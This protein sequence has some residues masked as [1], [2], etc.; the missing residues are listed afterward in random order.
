MSARNMAKRTAAGTLALAVCLGGGAIA[1]AGAASADANFKFDTRIAGDDRYATAIAA[2]KAAFDKADNVILVNGYATVDGLTASYLAGVANAP[3]LYVSDKGADDATKA[4]IKRLGAKNIWL[5]G[6]EKVIPTSVETAIKGDGYSVT[7]INGSDRYETAALIAE[8]GIK[9]SG[10]KPSKVFVASGTSFADALAVSPVAFVKGYP[11][12]LTEKDST[13]DFSKKELG[14][15]GTDSK[16]LVGGTAVVS[17]KVA[18]DLS[19]KSDARVAGADRAVTANLISDWAKKSEGFN[20]ANAALVGGTNGNGADSLVASALLGKSYTTLHFAGWDATSVYFKDHAAELTGKGFVFGGKAAV[21]EGQVSAAQSAAQFVAPVGALAITSDD[22]VVSTQGSR[23]YSVSGLKA[24]TEYFVA[25]VDPAQVDNSMFDLDTT[26]ATG[27]RYASLTLTPAVTDVAIDQKNGV[28]ITEA[29]TTT[30]TPSGST[31]SFRVKSRTA[32]GT[33]VVPVI[34][35]N[36]GVSGKLAVNLAGKATTQLAGVGGQVTFKAPVAAPPAEAATGN[37][38]TGAV[39]ALYGSTGF[40]VAGNTGQFVMRD[41]DTY[42]LGATTI[43]KA[44]F[45]SILGVGDTIAATR[46]VNGST[47]DDRS[48]FT[49]NTNVVGTAADPAVDSVGGKVT[50]TYTPQAQVTPNG[51]VIEL[52]R[53]SVVGGVTGSYTKLT[54]GTVAS[55]DEVKFTETLA[56]GTYKYQLKYITPG[57]AGTATAESTEVSH[58]VVVTTPATAPELKRLYTTSNASDV[59]NLSKGDTIKV[60]VSAPLTQPVNGASLVFGTSP[61]IVTLTAAASDATA[62][63]S[64]SFSVNTSTEVVDGVSQAA[65][66]VLTVKLLAAPLLGGTG[67]AAFGG[68]TL[69]LTDSTGIA[70]PSGSLVDPTSSNALLR[71]TTN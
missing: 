65:G 52:Y 34:F 43:T 27:N 56:D 50:V 58:N 53:A 6:G 45:Q 12:I 23:T 64:A 1:L 25:L 17:D 14:N 54:G 66:T 49:I 31:F 55:L 13:S 39:T 26:G 42:K 30:F 51:T 9:L 62:A 48:T 5:V 8:A 28:G 11:I 69:V 60:I 41:V 2:S 37:I 57:F 24:G 68:A 3:I 36:T 16:V 20:P 61:N 47:A 70:G 33:K 10:K 22:T 15:I 40:A 4:E 32:T 21:S 7:R 35:E 71:D 67:S 63:G 19:I 29:V 44:Q 59:N 46:Y 38:T 18:A